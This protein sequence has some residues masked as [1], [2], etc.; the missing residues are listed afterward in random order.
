MSCYVNGRKTTVTPTPT[1]RRLV[2]L[3]DS[4]TS[5]DTIT[6][7]YTVLYEIVM[8]QWTFHLETIPTVSHVITIS[9]DRSAT[10]LSNPTWFTTV[11]RSV[12]MFTAGDGGT[13][14]QDL[15]CVI[16]FRW[17]PDEIVSIT[18]PNPE[19]YDGGTQFDAIEVIL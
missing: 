7:S 15:V 12:D 4:I 6:V 1:P 13:P 16:P 11:L 8:E 9:N 10:G 18:F 5:G 14:I 3:N 2:Q 17:H 19:N